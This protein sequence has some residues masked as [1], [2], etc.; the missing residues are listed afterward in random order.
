[1]ARRKRSSGANDEP[2]WLITFLDLMTL[3]LTFFVFLISMAVIDERSKRVV[4]GSVSQAFG[5]AAQISNPLGERASDKRHEPG[6][7]QGRERDL[8]VLRDMVVDDVSKDL[9][10]R[11][12]KYVQILS[13]SDEVLFLP[14]GTVLS[15]EGI[16]L[17]DRIVPHLQQMSYPLLVA[18]HTAARRDEETSAYDVNPGAT[19]MDSTWPLSFER[20]LAVYRHLT[21]RGINPG[22]LSLEAFGQY[23]PR[24]NNNTLAGRQK[25]RRVDLVL[26]KRNREWIDKVEGLREKERAGTTHNYRGFNFDLEVPGPRKAGQ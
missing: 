23:H 14:G 6:P 16:I 24:Q 10:F 22:N 1:M 25:N 15:P 17:L 8:A 13:I 9:D 18:G 2:A 21:D 3:M 20:G 12:N 26:D 19:G 11:E 7:M 5:S 4:L